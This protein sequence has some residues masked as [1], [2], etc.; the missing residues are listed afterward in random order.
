MKPRVLKH[1]LL[2]VAGLAIGI[3]CAAKF[4]L[5]PQQLAEIADIANQPLT[6]ESLE[7]CEAVWAKVA[8]EISKQ[9]G[10]KI[11]TSTPNLIETDEPVSKEYGPVACKA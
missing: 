1:L 11:Q 4:R 10:F 9:C 3:A 2:A 7:E 8:S 6:C 5:T